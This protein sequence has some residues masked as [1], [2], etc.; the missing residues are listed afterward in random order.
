[1]GETH[2]DGIPVKFIIFFNFDIS[3]WMFKWS[4]DQVILYSQMSIRKCNNT[5]LIFF[6]GSEFW[7]G[8]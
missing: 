6:K 3:A 5:A 4:I 7:G 1:M 8:A 2:N